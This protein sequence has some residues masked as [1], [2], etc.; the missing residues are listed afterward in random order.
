LFDAVLLGTSVCVCAVRP[1]IIHPH[2]CRCIACTVT[3]L[4]VNQFMEKIR[5]LPSGTIL[6]DNMQPI[7]Q[8]EKNI[9]IENYLSGKMSSDV[10]SY[11]TNQKQKIYP[12][13]R[14]LNTPA[15]NPY[16]PKTRIRNCRPSLQLHQYFSR[17]FK[18][19]I[20]LIY[21]LI[22]IRVCKLLRNAGIAGNNCVYRRRL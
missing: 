8:H 16:F 5:R 21:H 6:A 7:I 19:F 9:S 14:H 1:Y 10:F 22:Y 20:V 18:T 3:F 15:G 4:T 12:V 11:I 17:I 13:P 2:P